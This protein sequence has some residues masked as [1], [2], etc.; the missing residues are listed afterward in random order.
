MQAVI[1]RGV[2]LQLNTYAL[3]A[4]QMA[5]HA[6]EILDGRVAAR[7]EHALQAGRRNLS[8]A[9]K[10]WK[11]DRR[12]DVIAKDRSTGGEVAVID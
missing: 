12:V 4:L 2:H 3:L 10:L 11:A 6:E 7:P 9:G 1:L 5:N 8:D